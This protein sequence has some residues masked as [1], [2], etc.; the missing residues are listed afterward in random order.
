MM[1]TRPSRMIDDIA[2]AGGSRYTFHYEAAEADMVVG[3][4]E[5]CR[6]I[7]S[8]GMACGVALKPATPFS[9][10]ADIIALVDLVL[11]MTVEPGF[12]GQS[13]MPNM[14]PKVL[15]LRQLHPTLHL[16]VDGGL[17]PKTID[18]AAAAGAN[19]IVAGSAVFKPG[20]DPAKPIIA[21]RRSV[22]QL[23]CGLSEQEAAA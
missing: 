18:A 2:N 5:V 6:Q 1:V 13:F 9:V 3:V 17:S 8:T 14:M 7:K 19:I 22:L 10:L 4:K 21:M 15:A 16:Q 23:G 20:V 11:V 12:G